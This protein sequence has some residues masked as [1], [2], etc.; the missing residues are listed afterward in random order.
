MEASKLIHT[1][2]NAGPRQLTILCR[3]EVEMEVE[4]VQFLRPNVPYS[5][6]FIVSILLIIKHPPVLTNAL[7][8]KPEEQDMKLNVGELDISIIEAQ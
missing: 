2:K 4:I 8:W 6:P 1:G 5:Y 7:Y 3:V